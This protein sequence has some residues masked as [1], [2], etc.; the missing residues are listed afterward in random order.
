MFREMHYTD[1]GLRAADLSAKM[2]E[3]WKQSLAISS[4]PSGKKW[5]ER[6]LL[7][8]RGSITDQQATG[9][10]KATIAQR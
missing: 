4:T 7:A 6:W 1:H 9:R 5:T 3:R 10:A 8:L 2:T